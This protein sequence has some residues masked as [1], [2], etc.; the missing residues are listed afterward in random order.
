MRLLSRALPALLAGV[1]AAVPAYAQDAVPAEPATPV[2]T[3]PLPAA[4]DA[5]PLAEI[6]RYVSVYRAIKDAYVEPIGDRELMRAA[7]RG[8]LADLD[9]HSAYLE[10]DRAAALNEQTTGRYVGIGVE[11]EQRPDR[12]LTVVA[13][14]D[15]SPAALAGLRSGDV[16]E[17]IDDKPITARDLDSASQGL[18]GPAGSSVKLRLRREGAKEPFEV[19][20]VRAQIAVHAVRGRLLEPG[21]GYVRIASFQAD[22]G[23]DVVGTV[24]RLAAEAGGTLKGLVLDLRSNPGGVL[25]AAVTSADAFLDGGVVVR[26][27]GRLA[28][29]NATYSAQPGDLLDGA[30]IVALID[31]GTASA[32][33]ILAGALQDRGRAKL[34]GSRS[35]GKG[36]IQS[37]VP[38]ANGDAVKITTG[39]YYTPN[40]HSI[41][42]RGLLPDVVIA[43]ERAAGLREQDLPGHL[44]GDDEAAD[45]FAR[46]EALPGDAPIAAGLA[47][48]KKLASAPRK[49][50]L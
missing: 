22:T 24:E 7:L 17:A 50:T 18:R 48:L 49:P 19:T 45:G 42:A 27:R 36:S 41:Q 14:V 31:S 47:E 21:Y 8:L 35:F 34:V 25:S 30:P 38:L 1:L 26:S 37:V 20:L 15:G 13:P 5:V 16:I 23:T 44:A 29:S 40:D 11:L 10:Q 6:Q 3:A 39:R 46:G 4:P 9:P 12:L 33:E 32:A 28:T 2:A 43:G